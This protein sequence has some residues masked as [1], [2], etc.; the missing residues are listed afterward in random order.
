M[1][2]RECLIRINQAIAEYNRM[3]ADITDILTICR[4]RQEITTYG[5][6]L[7]LKEIKI[8]KELRAKKFELKRKTYVLKKNYSG[9]A[10]LMASTVNSKLAKEN[11]E[12]DRLQDMVS[13]ISLI[14]DAYKD[15]LNS[16]AGHTNS[17]STERIH[18]G[19]KSEP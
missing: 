1:N 6:F 13:S 12:I 4:I 14:K 15:V 16:L 17:L 18:D 8:K 5:W 3:Q 9:K 7:V 2:L 10:T 11:E 19:Q